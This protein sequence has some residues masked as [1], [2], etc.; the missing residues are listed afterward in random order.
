[1]VDMLI[2]RQIFKN[3]CVFFSFLLSL[4][5]K[6]RTARKD[7]WPGQYIQF[8]NVL[9]YITEPKLSEEKRSNR[10]HCCELFKLFSKQLTIKGMTTRTV[11]NY[12]LVQKLGSGSYA[13]VS[14][15]KSV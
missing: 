12:T 7:N 4:S 15:N 9:N 1:M 14:C 6:K 11:G 8:R 13:H 5:F 2:V 3:M 10:L